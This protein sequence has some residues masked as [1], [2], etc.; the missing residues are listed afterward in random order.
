MRNRFYRV[1]AIVGYPGFLMCGGVHHVQIIVLRVGNVFFIGR[2]GDVLCRRFCDGR[3][4]GVVMNIY[5][6]FTGKGIYRHFGCTAPFVG[7]YLDVIVIIYPAADFRQWLEN[8][9]GK[10]ATEDLV[11]RESFFLCECGDR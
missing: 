6:C 3:R 1:G 5:R 4:L 9:A 7:N 8:G 10:L 2:E 11:E